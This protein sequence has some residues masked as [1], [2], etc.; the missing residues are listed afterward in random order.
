VAFYPGYATNATLAG[1]NNVMNVKSYVDA[2]KKIDEKIRNHIEK[3]HESE[4]K[5]LELE[6]KY[7]ELKASQGDC[8]CP[9]C[10]ARKK[11]VLNCAC[12][13]CNTRFLPAKPECAC[14][15][16]QCGCSKPP[17]KPERLSEEEETLLSIEDKIK[18]I[19]NELSLKSNH[20]ELSRMPYSKHNQ[21]YEIKQDFDKKEFNPWSCDCSACNHSHHSTTVKRSKSASSSKGERPI[22][23]STGANDYTWTNQT[24]NEILSGD[25]KKHGSNR[26]SRQS[27]N[28]YTTKPNAFTTTAT[29]TETR[30]LY[31][32]L[33]KKLSDAKVQTDKIPSTK[34]H[35]HAKPDRTGTDSKW[36]HTAKNDFTWTSNAVDQMRNNEHSQAIRYQYK[37]RAQHPQSHQDPRYVMQAIEKTKKGSLYTSTSGDCLHYI[38]DN[39]NIN[40]LDVGSS[41][42]VLNSNCVIIHE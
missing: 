26:Q 18:K 24:R 40:K 11:P 27:I 42:K 1:P 15:T 13:E 31:E 35:Y 4:V 38:P 28:R 37:K 6:K 10:E 41:V 21:K 23:K 39:A 33:I 3:F 8:G 34:V 14:C 19:R 12:P 22:W 30:E 2:E 5:K 7:E 29:N 32:K 9:D 20:H 36:Q 25:R 16:N 17:K